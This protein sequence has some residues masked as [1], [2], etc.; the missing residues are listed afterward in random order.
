[1]SDL[2]TAHKPVRVM[3]WGLPRSLTT[4]LAKCLSY[5][6]GIYV[7][8]EAFAS[9]MTTGPEK[10][11]QN[12]QGLESFMG[13]AATIADANVEVQCWEDSICTFQ[14]VKDTMEADYPGKKIIFCK[15]IVT[16]ISN[17]LDMIPHGYRHTF[18]IRHPTKTFL[19][20]RKVFIQNF[21]PPGIPSDQFQLD[22]AMESGLKRENT[23]KII[24]DLVKHLK[25]Q[26]EES[27]PVIVDADDLQ[28]HTASI[29]RQYCEAVGI[30]Y[31]ESLLQWEAGDDIIKKNWYVSKT[32]MVGNTIGNYY[33]AALSSTKFNPASEPP[34]TSEIPQDV[35]R[36]SEQAMPYYEELYEM[37]LKP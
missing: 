20:L 11:I 26:G 33:G 13:N 22:V 12:A 15:D 29:L 8:N 35:V 28:N 25:E 19:S 10:E 34:S 4:V 30:P 5:V 21:L 14:W 18:I 2:A 37:R 36:L 1:M 17:H 3:L 7:I 16:S 24:A 27:C 23:F 31:N 6:D 32:F 9:A